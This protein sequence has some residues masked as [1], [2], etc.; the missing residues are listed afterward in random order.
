MHSISQCAKGIS[1]WKQSKLLT[2][3]GSYDKKGSLL[4]LK[5]F[6]RFNMTITQLC[7]THQ[8]ISNSPKNKCDAYISRTNCVTCTEWYH[9]QTQLKY[10]FLF[11]N[12]GRKCPYSTMCILCIISQLNAPI[13]ITSVQPSDLTEFIELTSHIFEILLINDFVYKYANPPRAEC[14]D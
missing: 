14:R 11:K 8:N 5:I 9:F 7:N 1:H 6:F 2:L 13:C 3:L 10:F 4:V 12:E